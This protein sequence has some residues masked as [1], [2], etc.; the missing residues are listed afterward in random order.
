MNTNT[1]EDSRKEQEHTLKEFSAVLYKKTPEVASLTSSLKHD[2]I[3]SLC[4]NN[5]LEVST[6]ELYEDFM[7]LDLAVLNSL[8][9]RA[10]TFTSATKE[11]VSMPV[12][13]ECHAVSA[14]EWVLNPFMK[15][16]TGISDKTHHHSW[17]YD[18]LKRMLYEP[19]PMIRTSYYGSQVFDVL[20]FVDNEYEKIRK[21]FANGVLPENMSEKFEESLARLRR[22]PSL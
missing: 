19:T 2:V 5:R 13:S 15:L 9:N 4:Y 14:Y 10:R 8:I 18:P 20:A 7:A 6:Q 12:E 21:F 17:V 3:V 22:I 1:P 16:Y 11:R